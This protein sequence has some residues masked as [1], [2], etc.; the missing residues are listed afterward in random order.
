MSLSNLTAVEAVDQIAG[1]E[2]SAEELA[3]DLIETWERWPTLNALVNFQPD[4]FLENAVA[5]DKHRSSGAA[6]GPLHGLPLVAKDNFDVLGFPTTAA[7]PALAGNFPDQDC[8][9]VQALRDAGAIVMAKANMHELAFSPGI[10]KPSEGEAIYGAFGQSQNPYDAERSPAGSSSGTGAAVGAR[11]APAGLGTDTGGSI[12]N[13]AAWCGISGLRPTI[14]RYSQT[15]IVPISWTRDTAG[16]M[17]RSCADLQLLDSVITSEADVSEVALEDIRFG[18]DRD[19]Y[20][21]DADPEILSVFETELSRLKDA[22]AEIVDVEL[23]ELEALIGEA[24]QLIAMYEFIRSVPQY[25]EASDCGVS[26][27]ELIRQTAATGLGDKFNELRT[28]LA[29]SDADYQRSM[30][31]LRPAIQKTYHDCF[32]DHRLDALIFPATLNQP[33]KYQEPGTHLFRGKKVNDF[34]MVS[35]NVQPAS[36]GGSPGLTVAAGLAASGLPTAL[37]FDGPMG[38]DRALLGIGVAYEKIRPPVPAP[39]PPQ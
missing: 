39:S 31:T 36:I 1:G 15:G 33:N 35:H 16:P 4:P 20:C 28:S 37:G 30:E 22:G 26:F 34:A 3:A 23:P 27:D 5:A 7:S 6:C 18:I 11:L 21:A 14:K 17:A 29:I 25:L 32:R 8:P 10:S 24:G 2:I 9:V 13:P 12:R 19:F 38:S